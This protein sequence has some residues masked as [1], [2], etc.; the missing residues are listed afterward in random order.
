MDL[1]L[2]GRVALVTGGGRGIGR[3]ISLRLATEGAR[4]AV[5]GRTTLRLGAV[6]AEIRAAGGVALDLVADLAD[7]KG[8]ATAL[9]TLENEFGP[10]DVLVHNAAHFSARRRFAAART[11]EWREALDGNVEA[12]AALSARVLPGM[13]RRGWGRVVFVGSL[14]G[15]LGGRGYAIYAT[16]KAAQE[17]MARAIALDYGARGITANLVAPGFIETEH[18]RETSPAEMIDRNAQAAAVGRLGQPGEV[19]CAVAFLASEAAAFVSGAVLIVS[20][21]AHLN[22]RW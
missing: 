2:S 5:L 20:G 8:V 19:A 9:A 16:V 1:G 17:A 11:K 6:C 7:P 14:M 3:A 12:V 13:A 10:V 22:T 4:V 21:G 15:Q 18:L